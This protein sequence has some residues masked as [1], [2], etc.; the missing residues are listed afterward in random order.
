MLAALLICAE[1]E[2]PYNNALLLNGTCVPCGTWQYPTSAGQCVNYASKGDKLGADIGRRI[3]SGD[4][5]WML[6]ASALVFMMTPGLGFFYAGLAGENTAINTMM[7]SLVSIAISTVSWVLFGYSFAY[8][9]L[10]ND[11][12]GGGDW[13]ALVR[14]GKSPS[15]SYGTGIPHVLFAVFQCMFAQVTPAIIS[16]AVVGRMTFFSYCIFIFFWSTVV[17]NRLAHWMWCRTVN[18]QGHVVPLGWLGSLGAIDFAGGTVIHI[19]SGFA[20]LAAALVLGERRNKDTSAHNIPLVMQGASM[21]YFGWF[22]FNAGSA[23]GAN[24]LASVAF[25]NTHVSAASSILT[26]LILETIHK[27]TQTPLGAAFSMVVGLVVITPGCGFVTP[28]SA[29]GFGAIGALSSY[30]FIEL[31]GRFLNV[32]DTLDA[33]AC[34]GVSGVVGTLLTGCFATDSTNGI[35]GAFF[36]NPLLLAH[37]LCAVV[38]SASFAFFSTAAILLALKY[39]IGIRVTEELEEIG[40][41]TAHKDDRQLSRWQKNTVKQFSHNLSRIGERPP[42]TTASSGR[43]H[44][45]TPAAE[46]KLSFESPTTA[47]LEM[48]AR[49][50]AE[51]RA[52]STDDLDELRV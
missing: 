14:V 31:K 5:A 9:S 29:I 12:W 47:V 16:G 34:H 23:L 46:K 27:R 40:I 45:L 36:G 43:R 38:V 30:G 1:A 13:A 44:L 7:M 28:M 48:S 24:G 42:P 41:D 19:S 37:Q 49:R 52:A 26:W 51:V 35:N 39:T 33:F 10:G 21:L 50:A 15:G 3:D 8:S 4:T 6:V 2:C 17:Y 32:D 11:S 18:D 22:G 20:A 25:L